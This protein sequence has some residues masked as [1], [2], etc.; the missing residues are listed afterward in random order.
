MDGIDIYGQHHV[1]T[2]VM[3]IEVECGQIGNVYRSRGW[4]YLDRY[5]DRQTDSACVY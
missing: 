5:T 3:H 4:V 2:Y 1:D